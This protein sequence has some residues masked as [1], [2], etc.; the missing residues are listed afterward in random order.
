MPNHLHK[1]STTYYH[2]GQLTKTETL[3]SLSQVITVTCKYCNS[4]PIVT[5]KTK[6]KTCINRPRNHQ[7][8][9]NKNIIAGGLD[10]RYLHCMKRSELA[11]WQA[12]FGGRSCTVGTRVLLFS[13]KMNSH[14]EMHPPKTKQNKMDSKICGNSEVCGHQRLQRILTRKE[15]REMDGGCGRRVPKGTEESEF[16][17]ESGP[18]RSQLC[19][20]RRSIGRSASRAGRF[21]YSR[22]SVRG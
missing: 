18:G 16:N 17:E 20:R 13:E 5:A 8:K 22:T 15:R 19:T 1:H 11:L 10:G 3:V 14:K 2:K 21:L 6:N 7:G 12:L 9:A 4:P